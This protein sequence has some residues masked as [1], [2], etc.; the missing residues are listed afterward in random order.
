MKPLYTPEEFAD[1]M[2][3]LYLND[4]DEESR[5]ISMDNLMCD[6]LVSLGY[7]EAVMIFKV[8]EKFYA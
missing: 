3:F 1:A 8:T 2:R 6:L 4:A 7:A 5:H